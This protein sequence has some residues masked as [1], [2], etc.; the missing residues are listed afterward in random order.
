MRRNS[1]TYGRWYGV[2][3]S[4]EN[5]KQFLIPEG[6]AHGFLVLSDYADFLYKVNDF[7]HKDDEDGIAWNDPYINIDWP[8]VFGQYSGSASAEGYQFRGKP[9]IISGKDPKYI[10][11]KH[12]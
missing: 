5:R 7:W 11:L 4:A 6:F 1:K 2:E 10:G 12:N 3:L 9:L 8:E